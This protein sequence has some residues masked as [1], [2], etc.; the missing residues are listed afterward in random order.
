M[1]FGTR[2]RRYEDRVSGEGRSEEFGF[3][4]IFDSGLLFLLAIRRPISWNVKK[5]MYVFISN[6][7]AEKRIPDIKIC[8]E[9]I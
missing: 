9:Q 4:K 5:Y 6:V 8:K 2:D 1:H 3:T 7:S